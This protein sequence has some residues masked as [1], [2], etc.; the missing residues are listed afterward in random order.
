VVAENAANADSFVMAS[1]ISGNATIT[2]S[3]ALPLPADWDVP[4]R[5]LAWRVVAD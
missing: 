4:I 3:G 2:H 1:S 5:V